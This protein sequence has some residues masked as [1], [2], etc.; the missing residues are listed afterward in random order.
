MTQRPQHV[1]G[2]EMKVFE[3]YGAPQ[4]HPE[5]V[6][7]LNGHSKAP[8]EPLGLARLMEPELVKTFPCLVIRAY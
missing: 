8:P 2:L 6:D 4:D 7:E 1:L 5:P 3:R